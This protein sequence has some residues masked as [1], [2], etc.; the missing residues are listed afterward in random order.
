MI[1]ARTGD[2]LVAASMPRFNPATVRK[3]YK[4][5]IED[6]DRP[7]INRAAS[8]LYPMGSV[9]KVVVALAGLETGVLPEGEGKTYY[10]DGRFQLGRRVFGCLGHHG[11]VG[12]RNAIKK[13]CNI[14]F[15]KLAIEMG[16]A[17]VAD[18]AGRLGLGVDAGAEIGFVAPGYV[19][20]PRTE[21]TW[22]KGET[23]NLAIGQGKLQATPLQVARLMAVFANGGYLVSPRIRQQDPPRQERIAD[24]PQLVRHLDRI[25][26]AMRAVV[27][28]RGGTGYKHGRPETVR[29]CAKTGTA[30]A[31]RGRYHGWYAGYTLDR[32]GRGRYAFAVILEDITKREGGGS[33]AGPVAK[34]FFD[35]IADSLEER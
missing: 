32:A 21:A 20:S 26:E 18:W 12:L 31:S 35:R 16:A 3:D 6:P 17:Q 2:V 23:A 8:G 24:S 27:N 34:A 13:S 29:L 15:Y 19:P 1:D 9:F 30:Q 4:Q 22:S 33:T 14:F 5:L 7:L 28:E 25:S 11:D 10:C